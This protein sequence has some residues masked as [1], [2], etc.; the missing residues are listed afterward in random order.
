[1]EEPS[2]STRGTC[3]RGDEQSCGSQI[4]HGNASRG[5]SGIH[6][7]TRERTEWLLPDSTGNL[8]IY[9][10]QNGPLLCQGWRKGVASSF[11]KGMPRRIMCL[12]LL[13]IGQN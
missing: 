1:M 3:R 12:M 9:C 2:C 11:P 13:K 6:V 7:E 10:H 4:C 5:S 8:E